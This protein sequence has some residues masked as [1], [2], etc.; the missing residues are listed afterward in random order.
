MK[1]GWL[2]WWVVGGGGTAWP[3]S[4]GVRLGA[5]VSLPG[6]SSVW[7][8]EA[9]GG[10]TCSGAGGVLMF[11]RG[12]G[13]ALTCSG[14]WAVYERGQGKELLGAARQGTQGARGGGSGRPP[15]NPP[16]QVLNAALPMECLMELCS[17][18]STSPSCDP[19]LDECDSNELLPAVW[20]DL[21][22]PTN[23]TIFQVR[24]QL[25][26]ARPGFPPAGVRVRV[27]VGKI[28]RNFGL[29]RTGSCQLL[30]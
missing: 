28:G 5:V 1:F 14:V 16:P 23:L 21:M 19:D 22:V 27:R 20:Q 3:S 8:R 29:K 18:M 24:W 13:G 10:L 26:V 4:E 6:V 30:A 11:G 7:V 15:S 12:Q 2:L 17:S 25:N 9:S